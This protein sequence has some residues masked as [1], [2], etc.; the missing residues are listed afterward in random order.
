MVE[1]F[2]KTMF[3]TLYNII[4]MSKLLNQIVFEDANVQRFIKQAGL[5]FDAILV[6]DFFNDSL[7]MFAHKFKA[8]VITI[9]RCH[10]HFCFCFIFDRI[11]CYSIVP[12]PT[13]VYEILKFPHAISIS[14]SLSL[15][16]F[17]KTTTTTTKYYRRIWCD[18]IH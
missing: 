11:S 10:F 15:S 4:G 16:R 12:T 9:C 13:G 6:E 3:S 18:G 17:D 2:S 8:P 14:L 1:I 5:H 7:L